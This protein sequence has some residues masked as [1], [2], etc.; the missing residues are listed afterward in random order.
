[1]VLAKTDT[2]TLYVGRYGKDVVI[3][4]G[5]VGTPRTVV[6]RREKLNDFS[7]NP[8]WVRIDG[9]GNWYIVTDNVRLTQVAA[10]LGMEEWDEQLVARRIFT[11]MALAGMDPQGE[12]G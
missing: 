10:V 12:R 7:D 8:I 11:L 2:L 6:V 5:E 9:S 4:Y 1:M 3:Q